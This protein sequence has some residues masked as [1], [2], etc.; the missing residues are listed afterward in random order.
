MSSFSD[1]KYLLNE[2]YKDA[3]NLNA[4]I[5]LHARFSTN[6]YG[7]HK[8]LFDQFQIAPGSRVLELGCGPG[9]FWASNRER[10]PADWQI[11]LSDFSSG[12]LEAAQHTLA[13]I[14]HPFTFQV[15][16]A[17]AIPFDDASLDAVI[18]NHM[19][20]HVPNR[21]RALSEIRRVLKPDGRLYASTIGEQHL[22]E[23]QALGRRVFV[24]YTSGLEATPFSLENGAAQLA[25]YFSS[26][27]LSR[28][29]GELAVT[30]SQP[31]IDYILSGK[32]ARV[33][34]GERLERLR[35]LIEQELAEQGAIHIST[36]SGLF[37]AHN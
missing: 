5:L 11:T 4:R 17:Q 30:E 36:D 16:D 21:P 31:L 33:F 9:L 18:A 23:L 37:I 12:M 15:I 25:P 29:E 10:I 7:W 6:K 26:V 13:Q 3:S 27:T 28:L 22:K 14:Q 34:V 19:L 1:Q 2:Q 35:L 32:G 24:A 20:Y 8:W